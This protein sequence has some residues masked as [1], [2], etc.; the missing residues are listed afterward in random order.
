[1][2]HHLGDLSREDCRRYIQF[3]LN[4]AGAREGEVF[5]WEAVKLIYQATGGNPGKINSLCNATMI[6]AYSRGIAAI[7]QNLVRRSARRLHVQGKKAPPFLA[8]EQTAMDKWLAWSIGAL[9][10]AEGAGTAF[11]YQKGWFVPFCQ[12][13]MK[14]IKLR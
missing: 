11:A 10:V 7:D 3:R 14:S 9:L 13:L 12:Y 4:L 6:A 1:V 2:R 8:A 5:P